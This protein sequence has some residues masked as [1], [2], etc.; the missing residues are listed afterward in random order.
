MIFLY[1]ILSHLTMM[2]EMMYS[3]FMAIQSA[4]Q[5]SGSSINGGE[6]IFETKDKYAGWDGVFKGKAQPVSVYV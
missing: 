5:S 2:G 1:L 3:M 4:K 6:K